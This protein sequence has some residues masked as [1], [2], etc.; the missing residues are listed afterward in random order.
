METSSTD[1]SCAKKLFGWIELTNRCNLKCSYCY[2]NSGGDNSTDLGIDIWKEVIAGFRYLGAEKILLSG[3]EPTLYPGLTEL[4]HYC[5]EIG[6]L[7]GLVTNGLALNDRIIGALLDAKAFVQLSLDSVHADAY[8]AARGVPCVQTVLANL[9]RLQQANIEVQISCTVTNITRHTVVDLIEYALCHGI[10]S[11][12]VGEFVP[13]GR[14][15]RHKGLMPSSLYPVYHALYEMQKQHYLFVSIDLIESWL[16]PMFFKTKKEFFCNSM[17]GC[18]I[19]V[20]SDGEVS[21]CDYAPQTASS[22]NI[23]RMSLQNAFDRLRAALGDRLV[24]VHDISGCSGCQFKFI[25]GGGCRALAYA[26]S[27]QW[28]GP[29]PYC[30]DLKTVL[31][32]IRTD[33]ENGELDEMADFVRRSRNADEMAKLF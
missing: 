32:E 21:F 4:L 27:G 29:H 8:F 24:S 22:A 23:T 31:R 20:K 12:R 15:E 25:C 26:T 30:S 16:L 14:G 2:A 13:T 5:R 33:Y 17:R 3:G 11:V 28:R 9:E 6:L 10:Q 1:R 19:Q 7:P 18:A